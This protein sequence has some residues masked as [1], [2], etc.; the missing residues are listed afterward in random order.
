MIFHRVERLASLIVGAAV[1]IVATLVLAHVIPLGAQSQLVGTDL[2]ATPAPAFRLADA[3][4]HDVS[5]VGLRG[6]VVALTFIYT[7]CPDVCPLIT[8]KIEQV[9]V[10]LGADA[11]KTAF[12]AITVDPETD[13]ATRI[14]QYSQAMGMAGK[15]EFLTGTRSELTPIWAAYGVGPLSA[16]QAALLVQNGPTAVQSNP[17]FEGAHTAVVYL[18]DSLGREQRLLDPDFTPAQLVGDLRILMASIP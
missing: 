7:S 1:L 13:T 11:P 16:D 18:I 14:D 8:Q 3:S 5:L 15:W 4:G 9:Y 6:K 2:N 10:Q 12:V 17:A